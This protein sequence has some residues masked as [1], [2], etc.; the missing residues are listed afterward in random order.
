MYKSNITITG[1]THQYLPYSLMFSLLNYFN[2]K[3]LDKTVYHS[4]VTLLPQAANYKNSIDHWVDLEVSGNIT[5]LLAK[6]LAHVI[7][8]YIAVKNVLVTLE[9]PN[10]LEKGN[11]GKDNLYFIEYFSK[12]NNLSYVTKISENNSL[13]KYLQWDCFIDLTKLHEEDNVREICN[14]LWRIAEYGAEELSFN[15]LEKL[16]KQVGNSYLRD[17]YLVQLQFMRIA[18]MHY[19]AAA[20]EIRIVSE[21]YP[22]L[23]HSF[24]LTKAW[25]NILIRNISAAGNYFQLANISEKSLPENIDQLYRMNIFALYKHLAGHSDVALNI[26]NKIRQCISSLSE[27]RPQITYINAINLARLFRYKNDLVKAKEYYD[28]AFAN[29]SIH[30]E[31]HWVYT[32]ICYGLLCEKEGNWHGA[33][34]HWTKA[35]I[36]WHN[37]KTPEAL[38]WRAVRAIGLFDFYPHDKLNIKKISDCFIKKIHQLA[39]QM[40]SVRHDGLLKCV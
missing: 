31:S 30:S 8:D 7:C 37:M 26:E 39:K 16:I 27:K 18:S 5:I 22:D 38:A 11:L 9:V 15:V 36:S 20:S 24:Y 34:D 10:N 25:G 29:V 17:L 35:W 23:Q 1:S 2:D 19:K 33:F 14:G 4:F 6:Q 21:A 32:S 40:A 3:D 13:D 28:E 12:L